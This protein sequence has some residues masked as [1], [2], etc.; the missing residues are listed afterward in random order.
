M[1]IWAQQPEVRLRVVL[2][3]TVNVVY[4]QRN[5]S[6]SFVFFAPTANAAS[7]AVLVKQITTNVMRRD[8]KRRRGPV[9]D[10]GLPAIDKAAILIR[11]LAPQAAKARSA[12]FNYVA[13][14][15]QTETSK[16]WL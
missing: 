13:A 8:V 3:I 5:S 12:L 6:G 1:M 11:L 10:P 9:N 14:A 15:I 16:P 7:G 4:V 2:R